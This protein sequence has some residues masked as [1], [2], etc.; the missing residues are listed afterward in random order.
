MG[1]SL[2]RVISTSAPAH[3]S[4]TSLSLTPSLSDSVRTRSMLSI[5]S[6]CART[7]PRPLGASPAW[8][9]LRSRLCRTSPKSEQFVVPWRHCELRVALMQA[10]VETRNG[11]S[12][13]NAIVRQARNAAQALRVL[14]PAV[15]MKVQNCMR[16]P[17]VAPRIRLVAFATLTR[18]LKA[19]RYMPNLARRR[20]TVCPMTLLF[21]A[22]G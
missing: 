4:R 18:T 6:A 20:V 7:R 8:H 2:H 9:G 16:K 5:S 13:R 19:L 3:R 10:R 11:Q 17:R 14:M 1:N 15:A 22:S 12:M 21:R